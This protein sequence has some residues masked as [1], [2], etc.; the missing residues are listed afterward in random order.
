MKRREVEEEYV[1][2]E[3]GI[4][5]QGR[6]ELLRTLNTKWAAEL[7]LMKLKKGAV[8]LPK[9][10]YFH[11]RVSVD[12]ANEYL[13]RWQKKITEKEKE[14]NHEQTTDQRN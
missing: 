12:S 8:G 11:G 13:A 3:N 6:E 4:D 14:K 10:S 5:G 2:T 7:K 9:A 1:F